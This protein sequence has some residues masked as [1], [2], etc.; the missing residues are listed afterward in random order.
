M[1]KGS[2]AIAPGVARVQ[3]L[4]AI[5]PGDYGTREELMRVVREAIAGAL[6]EEMRPLETARVEE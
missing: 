2:A 6:P 4:Q 3:F 1:R 5:L